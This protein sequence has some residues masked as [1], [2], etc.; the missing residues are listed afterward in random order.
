MI[1][2]RK[3]LVFDEFLI[4]LLSVRQMKE[5]VKNEK[6]LFGIK[7]VSETE[8]LIQSL[9]YS[10][11]NAQK[12]VWQEIQKDMT[13][14]KLMARLVQGDVG[15]GKTI[16][17]FLAMLLS[18]QNGYQAALM[19][20][21][22]VLAV[23]HFESLKQLLEEHQLDFEAV[24][25][26]GSIKAKERREIYQKI[27]NGKAKL[28]R[29]DYCDGLGDCLPNCP[30]DANH[31]VEREAAAYDAEAVKQNMLKKQQEEAA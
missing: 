1:L 26:T 17:A 15:S 25:L 21:T 14:E 20:P 27:E 30:V 13:G 8:A 12:K 24:L 6:N 4:F 29:D 7:P 28:M 18:A 19:V 16:L 11:T 23:Q 31:F 22:E 10:L 3:R 9:P 5:T 2:A